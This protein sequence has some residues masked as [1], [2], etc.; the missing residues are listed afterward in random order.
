MAEHRKYRLKSCVWEITLA[1]CFSCAYC[2][3]KAGKARENELTL[4]ECLSVAGQL[5]DLGC[6]RVSLL[7]GE[8]FMREDWIKIINALTERKL[9]V[10]I[11][12]N[13]FLFDQSILERLKRLDVESVALSVDGT[14]KI[15][16][17]YR[18]KGSYRR[19]LSAL[20]ALH[21]A[22]IPVSVITTL[23]GEN[24]FCLEE[25]YEILRK[26]PI[27]AWQLQACSPMGNVSQNKIPYQFDA[28]KVIRFVEEY[29]SDAPFRLGVAD[30]IGYYTESE[31]YLRGNLSE[32]ACFRGCGAGLTSIGIDSIGNV[33]GCEAMYDDSFIEGN[34]RTSTLR[35]I[36]ER[37]DAFRYNRGFQP[38]LLT[39]KCRE[40][41][42]GRVCAGGCRSYNYFAHGKLYE[43]PLCVRNTV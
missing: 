18:Q 40:C 16:D 17:K 32:K 35:E 1:C 2:G 21:G 30:N 38:E 3:S 20:K 7:G 13:G 22:G 15:H 27:F 37:P 14:E 43:S 36:W 23:N 42:Y 24:I 41:A 19:A 25:M 5:A 39:G 10:S 34:I 4:E 6:Q 8:V 12:T 26:S 33:H 9:R 29:A 31:G 28:Q 11:I